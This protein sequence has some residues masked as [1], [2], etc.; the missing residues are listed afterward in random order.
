M[1]NDLPKNENISP[2]KVKDDIAKLVFKL[3]FLYYNTIGGIK[4]PAPIHYANRL[5]SHIG[6]NSHKK[7]KMIPH[8][9]LADIQSLYFI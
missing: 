5:S 7:D 6:E 4:V 3:S 2:G 8:E 9:H 1:E